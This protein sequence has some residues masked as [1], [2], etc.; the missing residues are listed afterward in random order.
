MLILE[1]LVIQ[2]IAN[3]SVIFLL[4]LSTLNI[5]EPTTLF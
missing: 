3:V 5:F 4:L 1:Y 2:W